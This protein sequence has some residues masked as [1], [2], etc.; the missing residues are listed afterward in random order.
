MFRSLLP[1]PA[2][3]AVLVGTAA[4]AG[5]GGGST[6]ITTP[7]PTATVSTPPS[8]VPVTAGSP[9]PTASAT[10]SP[11]GRQVAK[12]TPAT[13]L[14]DTQEVTVT[15]SGF[16]PNEPLQVVQC[17]DKGTA[18]ASGDC[19]LAGMLTA[20]SDA[21]GR[22]SV[23]LQVVR[24]PFGLS[25]IVCGTQQRCLVSVTQASPSPTEEADAPLAFAS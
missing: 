1:W 20:A 23:K 15:A 12:V 6:T 8:I 11:A 17:A 2:L 24:G 18:T 13:G 7:T 14:G 3:L 22:L 19:N 4:L 21:T 5:C 16:S 10:A 9:S 25:N